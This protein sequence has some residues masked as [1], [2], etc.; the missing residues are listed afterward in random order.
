M[1]LKIRVPTNKRAKTRKS[2]P[3]HESDHLFL[4]SKKP[5]NARSDAASAV[6]RVIVVVD[7]SFA[8]SRIGPRVILCYYC[9]C[10]PSHLRIRERMFHSRTFRTSRGREY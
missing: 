8:L 6:G 5:H 1:P 9:S 10:L 3:R 2:R 7:E 4:Q